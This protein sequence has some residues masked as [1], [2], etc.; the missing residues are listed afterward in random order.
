MEQSY[1]AI[2]DFSELHD[3][4][5]M[6]VKHYSSGMYMRLGFSVAIHVQPDLLIVDEI[7]A[8]GDQAFQNKC[9][10][11]VYQMISTSRGDGHHGQSQPGEHSHHLFAGGVD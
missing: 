7:L 11:R 1:Q 5:H 3:Y 9:T 6:P 2:V 10:Q 8:V 4:I